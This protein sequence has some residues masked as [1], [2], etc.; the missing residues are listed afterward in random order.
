MV[1]CGNAVLKEGVLKQRIVEPRHLGCKHTVCTRIHAHFIP[2]TPGVNNAISAPGA[3]GT[4]LMQQR[5]GILLLVQIDGMCP[6]HAFYVLS[7]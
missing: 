5:C 3:R 6:I 7:L 4:F 1:H 2:P